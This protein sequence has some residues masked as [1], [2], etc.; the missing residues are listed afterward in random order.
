MARLAA[1]S[2][3]HQEFLRTKEEGIDRASNS[4]KIKR[5]SQSASWEILAS[6]CHQGHGNKGEYL[7][8][9]YVFLCLFKPKVILKTVVNIV[10]TGHMSHCPFRNKVSGF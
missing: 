6:S 2:I 8:L 5:R 10:N 1:M 9:T 4:I 7:L 3:L